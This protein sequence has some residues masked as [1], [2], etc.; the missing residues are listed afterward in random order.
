L[1]TSASRSSK[2]FPKSLNR[3]YI[4]STLDSLQIYNSST[5]I[6]TSLREVCYRREFQKALVKKTNKEFPNVEDLRQ[7]FDAAD[8][9]KSGV[10]HIDE[11]TCLLKS[12][13]PSMT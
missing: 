11:V 12:F 6:K 8:L 7:V 2:D 13:D 5:N 3:E 1:A 4:H 10:L 9:D